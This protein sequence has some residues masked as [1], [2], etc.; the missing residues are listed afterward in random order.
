VIFPDA[1]LYPIGV[2][3][4]RSR[5]PEVL[6]YVDPPYCG[7][8]K[9]NL[10]Q[11]EMMDEA[12]HR[13]LAEVL[14]TAQGSVVLSGYNSE[15]YQEL[16]SDWS[17]RN[18]A[19]AFSNAKNGQTDC[20]W[21]KAAENC[22]S[23][24]KP[25]ITDVRASWKIH[26][27]RIR[28]S[29]K[30]PL[31][32]R[33]HKIGTQCN[34]ILTQQERAKAKGISTVLQRKLDK[35]ARVRPELLNQISE[36]HISV[37]AAYQLCHGPENRSH[38]ASLKRQFCQL[39]ESEKSQFKE[40]IVTDPVFVPEQK[41]IHLALKQFG[42]WTVLNSYKRVKGEILWRCRC[43]CG[44]L[45][46]VYSGNLRTGHSRCCRS[47]ALRKRNRS[48]APAQGSGGRSAGFASRGC[49]DSMNELLTTTDQP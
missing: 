40:W 44:N 16:Y 28:E 18:S 32:G 47:C 22:R 48:A 33:E 20:L 46:W 6:F 38:L 19:V 7:K 45:K 23:T 29:A 24:I 4:R 27:H 36:G 34:P 3:A 41:F 2:F 10:Y 1:S 15:L 11:H 14:H 5:G 49:D 42:D 13:R 30:C 26:R 17:G 9:A 43:Q 31:N 8:R 21:I 35:I 37:H 39:S 25:K 12:S